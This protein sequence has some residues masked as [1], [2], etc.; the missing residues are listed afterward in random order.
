MLYHWATG[1]SVVSQGQF[2]LRVSSSS[3][4]EQLTTSWRVVGSNPIWDS[5]FFRVYVSPRI[6]I[7][8]C[9]CYSSVKKSLL[10]LVLISS[11]VA[12]SIYS[13]PS[14]MRWSSIPNNLFFW[15]LPSIYHTSHWPLYL[16]SLT[17]SVWWSCFIESLFYYSALYVCTSNLIGFFCFFQIAMYNNFFFKNKFLLQYN[18]GTSTTLDDFNLFI[19]GNL[20]FWK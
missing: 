3:V 5:D 12:L 9:C 10:P 18:D 7:I 14:W 16:P 17:T 1:D 6:Y 19:Y 20:L 8:S 2:H 4:V 15:S 11:L 13:N